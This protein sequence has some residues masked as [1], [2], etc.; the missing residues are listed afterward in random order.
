MSSASVKGQSPANSK[1]VSPQQVE[2]KSAGG[3]NRSGGGSDGGKTTTARARVVRVRHKAKALPLA[4]VR[5]YLRV[6][7]QS[8]GISNAA[9]LSITTAIEYVLEQ[10]LNLARRA[11]RLDRK[12]KIANRHIFLAIQSTDWLRDLFRESIIPG[13]GVVPQQV[14][15][16]KR[17]LALV[18]PPL[19]QQ[20]AKQDGQQNKTQH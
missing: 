2:A 10:I 8:R 14:P 15:V 18:R 9:V 1:A 17:I 6:E 7:S 19:P 13:S 4:R 12:G 5:R 3:S 20:E 16:P 11:A